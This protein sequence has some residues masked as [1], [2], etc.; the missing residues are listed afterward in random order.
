MGKDFDNTNTGVLFTNERKETEKHPDLTGTIN[1]EGKE[2]FLS[3]WRKESKGGK[4]FLSLSVTPKEKQSS[5][6]QRKPAPKQE[7]DDFI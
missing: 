3:S 6:G 5:G 7:E 4:K 1:V 2:Y